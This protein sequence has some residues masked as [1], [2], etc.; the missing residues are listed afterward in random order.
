MSLQKDPSGCTFSVL[1]LC[2][3]ALQL[4]CTTGDTI[5]LVFSRLL[6]YIMARKK[7][8]ASSSTRHAPV[9][10]ACSISS[11]LATLR[12]LQTATDPGAFAAASDQLEA[13]T[14]MLHPVIISKDVTVPPELKESLLGSPGTPNLW[15]YSSRALAT[16]FNLAAAQPAAL[17]I[18]VD[19]CLHLSGTLHCCAVAFD[20]ITSDNTSALPRGTLHSSGTETRLAGVLNDTGKYSGNAVWHEAIVNCAAAF[21]SC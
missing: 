14:R 5:S 4:L 2:K 8:I 7:Q 15:I 19:A 11:F 16:A 3:V 1:I 9:R 10:D 13:L 21:Q 20:H 6:H 17:P 12:G 18:L